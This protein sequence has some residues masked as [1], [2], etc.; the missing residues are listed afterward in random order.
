[1]GR[2]LAV[3]VAALTLLLLP[4]GAY[5]ANQTFYV[6]QS[7]PDAYDIKIVNNVVYP[8]LC[9]N[10][11]V[12]AGRSSGPR[13]FCGRIVPMGT[14][15]A[16]SLPS[17]TTDVY[18]G[19]V[20]VGHGGSEKHAVT[21]VGAGAGAG[22]TASSVPTPRPR[23]RCALSTT[24]TPATWASASP[25]STGTPSWTPARGWWSA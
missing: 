13:A 14:A 23:K 3:S 2:I 25:T 20:E 15:C 19:N 12:R 10:P 11:D 1:M 6:N 9:H 7:D 8:N 18:T 24:R 22:G 17:G 21:L 4:S 5:A 16:S